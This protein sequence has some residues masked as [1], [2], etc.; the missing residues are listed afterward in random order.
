ML[1]IPV[2]YS[3]DGHHDPLFR[4]GHLQ[5]CLSILKHMGFKGE[6]EPRSF[7]GKFAM[8]ALSLRNVVVLITLASSTPVH[9]KDKLS[10][11]DE[12][13]TPCPWNS[14]SHRS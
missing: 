6:F 9:L 12:H 2:D 13:G 5:L 14:S 7:G 8:L 4:N 3:E 10:P 11:L 1:K